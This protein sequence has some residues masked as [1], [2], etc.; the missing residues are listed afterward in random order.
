[1]S[2]W[3]WKIAG[4]LFL[5][6]AYIGIVTPGIPWS[7]PC[8]LASYCFAK[9][10]DKW[11]NYLMNHRLFGPFLNDWN[12]KRIYPSKVKW[13]MFICMDASLVIIWFTTHNLKLLIGVALFMTFWMVWALRYPGSL[14]EYT[15]RKSNNKR[16]GWLK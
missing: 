14:E 16:I 13:I 12:N 7:T 11:H 8:I 3:L 6:V 4:L 5:G 9:G 1:M 2:K 10:S 15:R